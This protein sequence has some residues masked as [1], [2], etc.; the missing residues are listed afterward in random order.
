MKE[1]VKGGYS[2][3]MSLFSRMGRG[4]QIYWEKHTSELLH[5]L[6]AFRVFFVSTA[7]GFFGVTFKGLIIIALTITIH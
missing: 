1:K 5:F 7:L 6:K 4:N 2:T 3:W